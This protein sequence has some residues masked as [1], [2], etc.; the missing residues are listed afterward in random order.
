[1]AAIDNY[2][3]SLAPS[4][5]LSLSIHLCLTSHTLPLPCSFFPPSF[6]LLLLSLALLFPSLTYSLSLPSLALCLSL[7]HNSPPVFYL[8]LWVNRES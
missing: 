1:M 3:F 4:I 8:F 2:K 5:P 7:S 6:A